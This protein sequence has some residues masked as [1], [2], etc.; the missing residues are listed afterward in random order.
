M[1][2]LVHLEQPPR[3]AATLEDGQEPDRQE[4]LSTWEMEKVTVIVSEALWA[5]K[6]QV[7]WMYCINA[8]SSLLSRRVDFQNMVT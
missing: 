7:E 6:D 5:C 1:D 4:V 8:N 2:S 3:E